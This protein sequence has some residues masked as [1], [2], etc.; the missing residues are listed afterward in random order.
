MVSGDNY[1][2]SGLFRY[3]DV[4]K[5]IPFAAPPGRFEKPQPHPGWD[6]G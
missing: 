4:Y 3:M 6:G 2:V 1:A 5:G